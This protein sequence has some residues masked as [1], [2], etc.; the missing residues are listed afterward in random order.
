[1]AIGIDRGFGGFLNRNDIPFGDV[2]WPDVIS[3][4]SRASSYRRKIRRFFDDHA[5]FH[6]GYYSGDHVVSENYL[7]Q[8]R[9][10][11]PF[12]L[13]PVILVISLSYLFL[14]LDL[15]IVQLTAMSISFY[16][17][18]YIDKQYHVARSWLGRFSWFRRKQ[19]LHFVHHRRADCN[20]AVIDNFWDWLLGTYK[21]IGAG[22]ECGVNQDENQKR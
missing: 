17:H 15:F 3:P 1:M 20:F 8:E 13:V 2:A 10:N 6:H 5:H 14:S 4:I 9:N 18:V 7:D 16:A 21:S 12:F 22:S 11:T 19:Q